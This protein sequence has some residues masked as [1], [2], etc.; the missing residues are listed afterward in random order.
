MF[1]KVVVKGVEYKM[2]HIPEAQMKLTRVSASGKMTINETVTLQPFNVGETE[3]T[4]QL[5]E[6]VM[7]DN[8]SV[9]RGAQMPVTNVSWDDCQ[10]FIEKL[11]ALT[12][13]TFSLPTDLEWEY[14]ASGAQWRKKNASTKVENLDEQA[15]YQRN[16]NKQLHKVKQKAMNACGLYDVL[17]N[18]SE[19]CQDLSDEKPVGSTTDMYVCRGGDM[20]DASHYCTP[21]FRSSNTKDY[22]GRGQGLRLVMR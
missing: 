10:V 12:G 7:G 6:A 11:N 3:V 8:P 14:V 16:S 5:W 9:D 15:W 2:I 18:V 22:R 21:Y 20:T 17:G 13:R 19:W 1:T 4:Q